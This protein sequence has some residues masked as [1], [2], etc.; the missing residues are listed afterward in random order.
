MVDWC[1][2]KAITALKKGVQLLKY[3]RR[4]KC[5]FC[6][7]KLSNVSLLHG[8]TVSPFSSTELPDLTMQCS[9]RS[10]HWCF[11][12]ESHPCNLPTFL[13]WDIAMFQK[14]KRDL[15]KCWWCNLS[16]CLQFLESAR[17]EYYVGGSLRLLWN[18]RILYKEDVT[19]CHMH[20]ENVSWSSSCVFFWEFLWCWLTHLCLGWECPNL[21]LWL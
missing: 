10:K 7:F 1:L 5:K 19:F 13:K 21:V 9:A 2:V 3:G 16:D 8:W 17:L 20:L 11:T 6:P 4:G 15:T 12:L 18:V 14:L